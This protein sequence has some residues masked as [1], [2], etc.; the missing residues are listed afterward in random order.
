MLVNATNG[1]VEAL[2]IHRTEAIV[3]VAA[4]LS[5]GLDAWDT[6]QNCREFSKCLRGVNFRDLSTCHK[7]LIECASPRPMQVWSFIQK[8]NDEMRD[9]M[10]HIERKKY[11]S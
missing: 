8:Y 11:E 6:Y 9:C 4:M 2:G 5:S 1:M 3:I 7:L 10:E